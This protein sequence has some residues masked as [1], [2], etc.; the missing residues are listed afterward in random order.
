MSNVLTNLAA[1]L[2]KA[3]D[4]VGREL[5]GF[6]PASTI[7]ADGSERVAKGDTVRA[8]FTR[9]ASAVDVSE[10]MT[11]PEGADQTVDSKTLS[12]TK[13]RAVQIPYTGEDQR[14]LNN[15]I[16]FETVYGDQ[17]AQA[18]RT[19]TNEIEYDIAVEA[20]KNASRAFGTAGTTPF[21]S[22]FSEVAEVRQI[23][24]DNG[25]PMND[26]QGSIVM[27]TLA[28]TNLRQLAQLQKANES[29][30]DSMLRQGVLL[31]LQGLGLRESAGIQSHIAG[32]GASYV[33]NGAVAKGGKIITLDGGSGT[34]LAGDVVTFAGDTNKYVVN[35]TLSG[36]D[37]VLAGPGLQVAL[38]DD[39]AMTVGNAYTG[40]V[41]FHRRAIE[42]AI[43]AP[44][45]PSGGDS[46]DDAMLIQDPHSGLVFEV[47]VYKGY[48]KTMIEVAVAWGVKAWKPE[49]I[50]T[51]LG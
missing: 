34:V 8:S 16:G 23:L 22:S 49:Y 15:G 39:A 31:D 3:A 37:I 47:R 30:S 36:G 13:S 12:I 10:S 50:A 7:N 11:T 43:R 2:Y 41:A 27:N 29:G 33:A 51:L 20:Y 21:G 17:V 19:L 45:V 42:L 46:A 35:E 24:A 25:M 6:I 5:V 44:A 40:N 38:A 32:T 14:H 48:R 4:V 9:E 1:D 18:M 28:G 26:G